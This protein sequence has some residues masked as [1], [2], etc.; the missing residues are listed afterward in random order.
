MSCHSL[1]CQ[2]VSL[3]NVSATS[4][5]NSLPGQ[6][7]GKVKTVCDQCLSIQLIMAFKAP[8]IDVFNN[9]DESNDYK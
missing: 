5:V 3:P 2:N 1:T 7:R 9:D 6:G 4:E 8:L